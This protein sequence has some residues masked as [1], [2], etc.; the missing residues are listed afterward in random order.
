[1]DG[2]ADFAWAVS[3]TRKMFLKLTAEWLC[4]RIFTGK[5]IVWHGD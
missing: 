3:F 5:N 4:S 1:M 2:Q